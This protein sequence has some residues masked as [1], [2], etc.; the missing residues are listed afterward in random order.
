MAI[1]F[2]KSVIKSASKGVANDPEVKKVVERY[3]GFFH[4]LRKRLT[5]DEKF[6]LIL[7]IGANDS[8]LFFYLTAIRNGR[9]ASRLFY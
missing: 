2:I 7:T 5:P 1:K 9:C 8:M 3:P 6:G 4:F